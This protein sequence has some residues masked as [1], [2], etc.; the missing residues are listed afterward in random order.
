M[1]QAP[2]VDDSMVE[3]ELYGLAPEESNQEM[4][5]VE[6]ILAQ[7][8]QAMQELIASMEEEQDAE[9]NYG[10]D[11]EDYDQLFREYAS[12]LQEQSW[13]QQQQH[14]HQQQSPFQH[15]NSMSGADADEMD[16]S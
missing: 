7:E 6:Y 12:N 4:D 10:S 2:Q 15:D 9:Q 14:Q 1:R 13:Q 3:E 8:E 11:E 5:E 16:M